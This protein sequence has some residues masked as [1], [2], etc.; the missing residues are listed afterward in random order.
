MRRYNPKEI[1]P[2]WQ[3]VWA[4]S[5]IYNATEDKTR[6]KRYVLE[7]FHTPAARP[8]TLAMCATTQSATL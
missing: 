6:Q 3:K 1:E 4:E 8:C 7:Y 2:K 5:G